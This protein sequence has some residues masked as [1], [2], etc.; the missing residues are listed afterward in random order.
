MLISVAHVVDLMQGD[1]AGQRLS[2]GHPGAGPQ[3]AAHLVAVCYDV[4]SAV[5]AGRRDGDHPGQLPGEP[6]SGQA[7]L[8]AAGSRRPTRPGRPA[9]QERHHHHDRGHRERRR[10]PA[11]GCRRRPPRAVIRLVRSMH[12]PPGCGGTSC[13][14][15]CD[16]HRFPAGRGSRYC[17]PRRA[18]SEA[19]PSAARST[20][21]TRPSP[22]GGPPAAPSPVWSHAGSSSARKSGRAGRRGVHHGG[23]PHP[24]GSGSPSL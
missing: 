10:A 21:T 19:P 14:L 2:R 7:P 5:V 15:Y 13:H 18:H 3:L 11:L 24:A 4:H 20:A 23:L 22:P 17:G 6:G 16:H 8:V 12:L 9:A 1:V